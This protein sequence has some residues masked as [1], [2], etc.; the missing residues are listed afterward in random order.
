NT[1]VVHSLNLGL[2]FGLTDNLNSNFSAGFINSSLFDTVK[3]FTHNYGLNFS[4]KA[5]SN[6]LNSSLN[7]NSAFN[8]GNKTYRATVSSGYNL[9]DADV[10]SLAISFMRYDGKTFRGGSFNELITSL[11]YNHRF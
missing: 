9:T 2:G 6:K 3:S 11:S 4:H 8:K 5:L 7:L 10:V 1:T